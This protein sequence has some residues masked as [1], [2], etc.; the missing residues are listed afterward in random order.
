MWHLQT[1]DSHATSIAVKFFFYGLSDLSGK[2][3][4]LCIGLYIEVKQLIYL[5]LGDDK[6]MAFLLWS[7]I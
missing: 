3:E 4:Q 7:N 6:G 2:S 5:F 1:D